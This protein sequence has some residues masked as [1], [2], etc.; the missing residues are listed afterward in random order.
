MSEQLT[1]FVYNT[2]HIPSLWHLLVLLIFGGIVGWLAGLIMQRGKQ[3]SVTANVFV[4]I[5]GGLLA[6]LVV[7]FFFP[8]APAV[9]G[10]SLYSLATGV[11]GAVFLIFVFGWFR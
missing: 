8:D 4:G 5:A 6:G 10:I 11:L 7:M 3:M 1:N 9:A 2:L